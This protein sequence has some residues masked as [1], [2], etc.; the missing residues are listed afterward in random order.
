MNGLVVENGSVF[1]DFIQDKVKQYFDLFPEMS[2]VPFNIICTTS[3]NET[4]FELRP[5]HVERLKKQDI[6]KEQNANG[7]V[8][9]PAKVGDCIHILMNLHQ[10]IKF[11]EDK[12]LTWIGTLAHEITHAIDYAEMAKK[13]NLFSYDNLLEISNYWMFQLWTEYHARRYGYLFLRYIFNVDAES[14]NNLEYILNTEFPFFVRSLRHELNIDDNINRQLYEIMQFLG[15]FSVWCDLFPETFNRLLLE[16]EFPQL[17][18]LS[19]I[20]DF[21]R[22]NE[23][24]ECAYKNFDKMEILLKENLRY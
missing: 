13:E 15:R 6:E 12:S 23:S 24:L 7:R 14:E 19:I 5:E 17:M 3:L 20:F 10:I 1:E 18:V 11:T 21:L 8:I 4:H 16:K 9:L 22:E 2:P